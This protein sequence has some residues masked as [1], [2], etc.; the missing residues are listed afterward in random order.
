MSRYL[1]SPRAQADIGEIWDY[2][3]ARWDT[4]QAEI[5]IRTLK[6]GIEN[7]ATNPYLGQACDYI[8]EGYAKYII[9]SHIIFYKR[10]SSPIEI[11]RILHRRM[12]Y[13]LHIDRQS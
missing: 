2:T 12:D 10:Q 8:R 7:I 6:A 9:G 11:I 4:A 3:Q 1:L 5:Y 13:T